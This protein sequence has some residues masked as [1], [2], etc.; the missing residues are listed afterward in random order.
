MQDEKAVDEAKT[1]KRVTLIGDGAELLVV[2][3]LWTKKPIDQ[4]DEEKSE[5]DRTFVIR[6]V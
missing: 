5:P 3:D 4:K 1:S 2:V 6:R